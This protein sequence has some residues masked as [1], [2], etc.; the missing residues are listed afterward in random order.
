M[1]KTT[2][3]PQSAIGL[4]N[5]GSAVAGQAQTCVNLRMREHAL[6]VM[7]TPLHT[8]TLQPGERLLVVDGDRYITARNG[9]I[10]WGDAVLCP[11]PAGTLQAQVVGNF[12][13]VATSQGRIFLHR[14]D[15][16]Y[17][18]LRDN[19]ITPSVNLSE[20]PV[21]THSIDVPAY[22]FSTPLNSWQYPLPTADLLGIQAAMSRQWRTLAREIASMGQLS[23]PVYACVGVR[24]WDDRYASVSERQLMGLSTKKSHYRTTVEA[25]QSGGKFTGIPEATLSMS[26]YHLQVTVEQGIGSE[27]TSLVKAIDILITDE[28]DVANPERLDYRMGTV[29][30]GTRRYL[31][32]FG[33]ASRDDKAIDN[34]LLT[35][36]WHVLMSMSDLTK[37]NNRQWE[38]DSELPDITLTAQQQRTLADGQFHHIVPRCCLSHNGRLYTAADGGLLVESAIGNPFVVEHTHCITGSH[39]DQ[40]AVAVKP[41]YSGGFGRYPLYVFT[42]EGI[43]ALPQRPS[44]HYGE[45]RVITRQII[46]SGS[47]PIEGG[48]RVWF[49]NDHGQLCSLEGSRVETHSVKA[50]TGMGLAWNEVERELVYCNPEGKVSL[51]ATGDLYTHSDWEFAQLYSDST[52]AL[53]V[54]S[55]GKVYDLTREI[56]TAQRHVDY[57]THPIAADDFMRKPITSVTW[58]VYG[59]PIKGSFTIRGQRGASCHGFVINRMRID[60]SLNAPLHVRVVA[61][62]CRAFTLQVEGNMPSGT[63]LLPTI[64]ER[65]E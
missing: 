33:P 40:L 27:W 60:G 7:G 23:R 51:L 63:L 32:E 28:A 65:D 1:K 47:R 62:P 14:T 54:A 38:S 42:S 45:A 8:H 21:A 12:I 61:Q 55:D 50:D 26:A 2:I 16:G 39:I 37:F 19:G 43:F 10:A 13:V 52:R 35:S 25:V 36:K 53:G 58:N 3:T 6:E 48:G 20:R 11:A 31:M 18:L 30:T 9:S 17:E 64:V 57:L 15:M 59:E 5:A 22:T 46:D 24:L 44:G 49:F 56:T 34:D 4:H 29:N 41:I